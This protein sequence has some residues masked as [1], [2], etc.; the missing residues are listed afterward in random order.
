MHTQRQRSHPPLSSRVNLLGREMIIQRRPLAAF[1]DLFSA[2][3]TAAHLQG[4]N[5]EAIPRVP[6]TSKKMRATAGTVSWPCRVSLWMVV[7]SVFS[8]KRSLSILQRNLSETDTAPCFDRQILHP[9]IYLVVLLKECSHL[10]AAVWMSCKA[11]NCLNCCLVSGFGFL[12]F[13]CSATLGLKSNVGTEVV[14]KSFS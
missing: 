2:L 3:V 10:Q 4:G 14:Q 7:L 5:L 8:L 6:E 9:N 12:L 11:V 13:C 1:S